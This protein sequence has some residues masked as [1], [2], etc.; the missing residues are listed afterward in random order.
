MVEETTAKNPTV[1]NRVRRGLAVRAHLLALLADRP[2]HGYELSQRLQS[3]AGMNWAGK[4]G[5][6]Y[7]NLRQLETSGFVVS[8]LDPSG[9]GPARRVYQLTDSGRA[10]VAECGDMAAL[11]QL[12]EDYGRQRE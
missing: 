2:G 11:R 10:A 5:T 6:T 8:A 4:P 12:L 9:T 7:L 1:R 3:S